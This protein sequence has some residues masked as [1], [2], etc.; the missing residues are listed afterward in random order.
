[1]WTPHPRAGWSGSTPDGRVDTNFNPAVAVNSVATLAV[2]ADD[3]ILVAGS[4]TQIGGTAAPGLARLNSDGARDPNFQVDAGLTVSGGIHRF[5]VQ[6]DGKILVG[7]SAAGENN[8]I[9]L[10]ADGS[11]DPG[12]AA[13]TNGQIN[14]MLAETDGTIVLGGN[15]TQV[16]GVPRQGLARLDADGGLS[17]F[18]SQETGVSGAVK[19]LYLQS[20]GK[21]LM[22]GSFTSVNGTLRNFIAG[23][24][25][26]GVPE[27]FGGQHPVGS[28]F[29]YLEFSNGNPFGYYN[30]EGDSYTFPYMFHADLGME[31]FFDAQ[32]GN[33]GAYLYDFTS[34]TFFYTSPNFPFPYLYD[35]SLNTVLYYYPDPNNEGRYNTEGVRYFY[36]F[37]TGEIFSK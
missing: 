6:P 8:L 4:F 3:K 21:V 9:R 7:G 32:D 30:V 17:P 19:T 27:F 24:S 12:F 34:G 31:Y 26:N 14:A 28:G 16:N 2:Q 22:G 13:S 10:N 20:N 25:S 29:Y 1:M 35:F 37:N 23:L 5:A 11:V 33:G 15:F 36:R 18:L